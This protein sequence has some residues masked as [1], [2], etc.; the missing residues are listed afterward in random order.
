[1]TISVKHAFT[2][3]KVDGG[4][5]TLVRPSNWNAEHTIT[6]ATDK[7]LG[8]ASSGS[9]VVEE[10]T[11][12]AAARSLLDD[13]TVAAMLETL[14]ISPPTTGDLRL[15]L[16]T[17][18][19]TGW[20]MFNDGTI[21]DAS[22]GASRANADTEDLFTLIFDN[23]AD[24]NAPILTSAGAA[25]TRAAQT[26]AATAWAAHCRISLPKALGRALAVAGAGSGLTSRA[27][28][29]TAGGET[30]TLVTANLPPYTPAGTIANGAITGTLGNMLVS[31]GTGGASNGITVGPQV[32][33]SS[34]VSFGSLS[35]S[36][37]TSTFSGT[38]QGGT[39]TPVAIVQPTTFLN[40]M[41]K[42]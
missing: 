13:T 19:T 21:G 5:T 18:A 14:G 20:V 30:S 22:S 11:C 31:S 42:L 4:D 36:Q 10:I 27:L 15:T 34:L 1:M 33:S 37:G 38:A 35:I 16:K 41:V 40:V 24:A 29:V 32:G 8:R 2:S 7:L 26:N 6:L 23:I 3:P 9:G 28:G 25:T 12:T 39:S 17:T